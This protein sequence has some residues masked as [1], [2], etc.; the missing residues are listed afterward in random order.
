MAFVPDGVLRV[1]FPVPYP[2]L[3]PGLEDHHEEGEHNQGRGGVVEHL[4]REVQ[5]QPGATDAAQQRCRQQAEQLFAPA[6]EFLPVAPGARGVSR[7]QAH[8]IA[9]GGCYRGNSQ[10]N[11][12]RKRDKGAGTHNTVD[13]SGPQPRKENEDAVE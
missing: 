9:D 13:G 5:E 8:G 3:E 2:L 1:G 4:F 12:D 6:R 10:G 11:K 7:H